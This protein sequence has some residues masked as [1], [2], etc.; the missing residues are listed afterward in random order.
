MRILFLGD[1]TMQLNDASTYPQ[2]GWPQGLDHRFQEDVEIYNLAKNGRSTK[3]FIEEGLFDEALSL[4]DKNSYV[5]IEFGHNDEHT[6]QKERYTRPFAE[7]KD[8][9]IFMEIKIREKGGKVLFLTPIYR[10]HFLED[11]TLYPYEHDQYQQA[12]MEVAKQLNCPYI[13][14][15]SLTKRAIEQMGDEQSKS[16]FMNFEEGIYTNY[17]EGKSDNTHLRKKGAN[18]ISAI[19]IAEI[20]KMNHPISDLLI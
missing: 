6:H 3:S 19:F 7:Y 9:L 18:L 12:M 15:C 11:G 20:I 13:D 5:V 16:C 10:R 4:I 17:P 8:N 2:V 1:S 14:M